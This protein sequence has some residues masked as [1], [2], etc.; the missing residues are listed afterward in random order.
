MLGQVDV[1]LSAGVVP[2]TGS[3]TLAW[4]LV[5]LPLVSAAVLLLL[6]RRADGWGHWLGVLASGSAF[7][8]GVVLAI[9]MAG[10]PADE[11][12][13]DL[14]LFDW[15][16]VEALPVAAGMRIDPLS[17]AFVLLVTCLLYTSDAAD[18]LVSV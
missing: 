13:M 3:F 10:L 9:A 17:L 14:F 8:V 15:L 2:A 4:L 11:R 6:G 1:V 5:A 18:D 12:V 16:P 7:V